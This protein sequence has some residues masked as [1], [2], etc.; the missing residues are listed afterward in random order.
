MDSKTLVRHILHRKRALTSQAAAR[1]ALDH[2]MNLWFEDMQTRREHY[3]AAIRVHLAH[4]S[5]QAAEC[6]WE[7]WEMIVHYPLPIRGD[8]NHPNLPETDQRLE[9]WVKRVEALGINVPHLIAPLIDNFK[10]WY[11]PE[12]ETKIHQLAIGEHIE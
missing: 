5:E 7:L 4:Q 10:H 1:A 2:R 3:E 6:L 11:P 9:E 12:I 8:Y